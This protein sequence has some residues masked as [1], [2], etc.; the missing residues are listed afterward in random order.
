MFMKIEAARLMYLKAAWTS[1][2][3][4]DSTIPASAAKAFATDVAME[5]ASEAVQIH[6]G[7]GY[8]DQYPV[9]I[10]M[11]YFSGIAKGTDCRIYPNVLPKQMPARDYRTKA[12][13]YYG[14]G[15]DGLFFWDTYKRHINT[16]QWTTLR[17]LGHIEELRASS[18]ND[19]DTREPKLIKIARLGGHNMLRY[20]PNRGG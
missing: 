13:D 15:A 20:S 8:I 12:L 9:E 2:F 5:V 18:D 14:A 16:A 10:D 17:R 7:Y 11:A 19:S 1:D 4:G 6:G 3:V